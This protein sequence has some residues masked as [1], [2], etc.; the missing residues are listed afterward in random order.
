[1][2]VVVRNVSLPF[3]PSRPVKYFTE[4]QFLISNRKYKPVTILKS[5]NAYELDQALCRTIDERVNERRNQ[6]EKLDTPNNK[7]IISLPRPY[8]HGKC[9]QFHQYIIL[10][11][12][13]CLRPQD[14]INEPGKMVFIVYVGNDGRSKRWRD[15]M[16]AVD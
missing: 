4:L 7:N 6:W 9:S 13:I 3:Q 5:L 10:Q 8:K 15:E 1:M 16:E 11:F 2:Q 12:R 14:T